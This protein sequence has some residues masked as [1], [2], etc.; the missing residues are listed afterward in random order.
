MQHPRPPTPAPKSNEFTDSLSAEVFPV[1]SEILP[2]HLP[3]LPEDQHSTE[4][5]GLLKLPVALLF[6]EENHQIF[7]ISGSAS[8][9]SRQRRRLHCAAAFAEIEEIP[10]LPKLPSQTHNVDEKALGKSQCAD[11][12]LNTLVF[13]NNI[14]RRYTYPMPSRRPR[15]T[16]GSD[17]LTLENL[18]SLNRSKASTNAV[19]VHENRTAVI[20]E[21][22]ENA[23]R[24]Y[25]A[26]TSKAIL[27]DKWIRSQ[28]GC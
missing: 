4:G 7:S 27:F 10:R 6:E 21:H 12:E 17:T 9:H 24:S 2:R 13:R 3:C 22:V 25:D 16:L 26:G 8:Q 5:I 11:T 15:S 1:R 18:P 20:R 23:E 28:H 19:Y 14:Q